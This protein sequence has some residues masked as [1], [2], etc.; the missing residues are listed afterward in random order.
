MK[1][2]FHPATPD[3]WKDVEALFG[4]RGACGG[5]WCRFWKQTRS[6]YDQNRGDNN[7]KALKKSVLKGDVPGILAYSGSEAVGWCAV[8]PREK[9]TALA[10]SRVLQPVD[11]R[12]TWSVPCFFVRRDFRN[13]GLTTQLLK[14]AAEYARKRGA[15]L[16]EGYPVE[17]PKGK[18]PD[19]FAYTGLPPSFERAGFR[20]AA[21]RSP[22]RPIMRLELTTARKRK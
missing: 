1:L 8:E 22:R 17:A 21:R 13:R 6:E 15:G 4:E 5:C 20:E 14:A 9:F 7:R 18:M 3:R 19:A 11:D 16:L 10:R 12:P 2:Q